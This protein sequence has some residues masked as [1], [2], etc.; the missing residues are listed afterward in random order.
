MEPD[1][2]IVDITGVS[3]SVDTNFNAPSLT[4]DL[5]STLAVEVRQLRY[6]QSTPSSTWTI[7]HNF[8]FEPQVQ[9]F[10]SGSQ[11]VN[12]NITHLSVNQ[13]V[14]QFTVPTSGFA[15]LM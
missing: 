11:L 2:V 9:I 4:L 8:G 5:N 13:T 7:N 12:A 15:R 6:T 1:I 14:V 10:N 3:I